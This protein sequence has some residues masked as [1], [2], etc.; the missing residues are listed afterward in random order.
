MDGLQVW[1]ILEGQNVILGN[2]QRIHVHLRGI[3]GHHRRL[4]GN[5]PVD[6]AVRQRLAQ[7]FIA[8][9]GDFLTPQVQLR[10]L[11][12]VKLKIHQAEIHRQRNH[13]CQNHTQNN[14]QN[15][16]RADRELFLFQRCIPPHS[17]TIIMGQLSKEVN[18]QISSRTYSTSPGR[19]AYHSNWADS[20][21]RW[22]L[23][24][25]RHPEPWYWAALGSFC[26]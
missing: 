3:A 16:H 23:L 7:F 11:S 18:T 26:R 14:Y 10:R 8:A 19:P 5:V 24:R 4:E 12:G 15:Q 9:C 21:S 22:P 20:A 2:R 17:V 25:C 6:F 1:Q 13:R